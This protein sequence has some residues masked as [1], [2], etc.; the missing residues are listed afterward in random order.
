MVSISGV[1]LLKNKRGLRTLKL[2]LSAKPTN[3][4]RDYFE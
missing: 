1:L 3:L 2:F 4:Y